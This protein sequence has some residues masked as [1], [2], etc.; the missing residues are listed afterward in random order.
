LRWLLVIAEFNV[1][2]VH[3][4]GSKNHAADALSRL[5]L[6]EPEEPLSVEQAPDRF[7]ESYLF[8][9]IQ[10]RMQELCPVTLANLRQT[11]QGDAT[12]LCI[13]AQRPE[14]YRTTQFGDNDIIEYH[15][16]V[17][18]DW[19]IVVPQELVPSLIYKFL[20]HSGTH[21]LVMSTIS[22]HFAF[23]SMKPLI[24]KFVLT[25]DTCQKVKPYHPHPRILN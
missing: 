15:K 13:M 23:P 5:P 9:P 17:D 10:H 11:Q 21:R 4:D 19:C 6:L 18:Q 22:Q 1:R 24:E 14:N 16:S 8:Y 12:L 20:G 3:R 25:C 2:I 7:H